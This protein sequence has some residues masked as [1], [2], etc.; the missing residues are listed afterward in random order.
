MY[1]S[2]TNRKY[3]DFLK[4]EKIFRFAGYNKYMTISNNLDSSWDDNLQ[5]EY[6]NLAVKIFSEI[7]CNGCS[8]KTQE[9]HKQESS[10]LCGN[11]V[12]IC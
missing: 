4:N 7:C 9:D 5:F 8:C 1:V 10:C 6:Q 3:S 12:C 2:Y 11:D